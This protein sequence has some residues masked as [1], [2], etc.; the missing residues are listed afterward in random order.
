MRPRLGDLPLALLW[1]YRG[2]GTLR[3]E[4]SVRSWSLLCE[5]EREPPAV[6]EHAERRGLRLLAGHFLDLRNKVLEEEPVL[7]DP[8]AERRQQAGRERRPIRTP[9]HSR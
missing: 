5:H 4:A 6:A 8:S 1:V 2:Q 3:S 7:A 9:H